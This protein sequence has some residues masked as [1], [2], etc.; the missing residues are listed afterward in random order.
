MQQ[1]QSLRWA[2]QVNNDR[3][4]LQLSAELSSN[5]WLALW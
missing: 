5:T 1:T 3:M 2:S 4:T